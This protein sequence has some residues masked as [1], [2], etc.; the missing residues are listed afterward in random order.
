MSLQIGPVPSH[1]PGEGVKILESVERG[2]TAPS[3]A[4]DTMGRR[5]HVEWDPWAPVTPLG[6]LVF[7]CQ[8]LACSGLYARWVAECPLRYA[9]PNAPAVRDVLGTAVLAILSGANRYAHVTALRGDRVNPP[10]LGMEKVVS[11]DSLRRAFQS[12]AAARVARWQTEALLATYGPALAQPWIADLDVTVKPIYGHQEGAEVGYNP[13]KPGRPS[14]AYHTVFLRTLRVALDVEV[15]SGKEHAAGHGLDNLW[16]LWDRLEP[17]QRAWLICGDANFGNERIECECEARGQNYLF[18]QRSTQGVK[19]LIQMLERQ[20]G[21]QAVRDDWRGCE[22]ELQLGGWTRRRRAVVFRRQRPRPPQGDQLPLL[23]QGGVVVAGEPLYE[24]V[25]L[26]TNLKENLLT[27]LHLYRQRA[28][29]EN[30]YDELKNQWGWGGFTTRDLLRCQ[31][32]ARLVAQVYNW[33]NLFVR[34][35]DPARAREAVTSRPLL[36]HSVGRLTQSG[37][38]TTLRLTSTH[39]E[40]GQAQDLLTRLS[41]FLSGLNNTAEQLEPGERWRRVWRRI[42]EPYLQPAAAL[43]GGSG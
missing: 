13:H 2:V 19:Q 33:W 23:E 26:V 32:A 8:F 17:G 29:V 20:G 37:G 9:S 18:R 22:G 10:G 34:C 11:E 24:Y 7:F 1:P 12:E 5:V 16:R 38:Q 4:V 43:L 30:A 36:L 40:A 27:L 3:L 31:V 41:L 35:A 42:L 28:D 21:W 15:R 25:V 6:Q 39:A 14:H